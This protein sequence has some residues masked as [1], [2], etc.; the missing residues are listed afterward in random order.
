MPTAV[1]TVN[2]TTSSVVSPSPSSSSPSTSSTSRR[3]LRQTLND[4]LSIASDAVQLDTEGDYTRSMEAYQRSV[5]LLEEGIQMM[6]RQRDH[7]AERPGRDTSHEI[8]QLEAIREKYKARIALHKRERSRKAAKE[9]AA[10]PEAITNQTLVSPPPVRRP[11]T[12]QSA[13]TVIPP[14]PPPPSAPL[15]PLPPTPDSGNSMSSVL[16]LTRPRGTSLPS[17]QDNND[18]YLQSQPPPPPQPQTQTQQR[19]QAQ[20]KPPTQ[21]PSQRYEPANAIVPPPAYPASIPPSGNDK[22]TQSIQSV[23]PLSL[24]VPKSPPPATPLSAS[25]TSIASFSTSAAAQTIQLDGFPAPK[26]KKKSSG[27][28][29]TAP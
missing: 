17:N 8:T 2:H 26:K 15:P 12:P 13:S 1:E 4:A 6:R 21:V 24:K 10:A 18:H 28:P 14:P 20:S 23:P 9:A 16:Y 25:S 3:A 19:I 22:A 27:R 29:Q 5:D 7:R 11:R